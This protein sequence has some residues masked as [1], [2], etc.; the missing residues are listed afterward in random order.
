MRNTLLNPNDK[1]Y[2]PLAHDT[3]RAD[4]KDNV[5]FHAKLF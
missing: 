2:S 1:I 4:K 5:R 3:N